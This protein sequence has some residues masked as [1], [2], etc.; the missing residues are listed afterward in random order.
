LIEVIPDDTEFS[1]SN[2][3]V[4]WLAAAQRS[5][6]EVMAAMREGVERW[7]VLMTAPPTPNVAAKANL[8]RPAFYKTALHR[9]HDSACNKA[10]PAASVMLHLRSCYVS[11]AAILTIPVRSVPVENRSPT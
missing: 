5:A 2:A 7:R 8:P 4:E 1:S 6:G 11:K 3:L 10:S 9:S